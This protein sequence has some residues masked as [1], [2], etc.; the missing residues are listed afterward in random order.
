MTFSKEGYCQIEQSGQNMLSTILFDQS[1][2]IKPLSSLSLQNDIAD[3]HLE[4]DDHEIEQVE[5]DSKRV[6]EP[7][8]VELEYIECSLGLL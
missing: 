3:D 8:Q 1:P 6:V 7:T 2:L 4:N 5:D